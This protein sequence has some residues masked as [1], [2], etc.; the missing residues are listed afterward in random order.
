MKHIHLPYMGAHAEPVMGLYVEQTFD[1][2]GPMG[3]MIED[4][5]AAIKPQITESE[6]YDLASEMV[7]E[8]EGPNTINFDV[9]HDYCLN[10]IEQQFD[11]IPD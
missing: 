9:L 11:V 10:Q 1:P 3:L 6:A 8:L 7:S 4:T 5:F 2:H